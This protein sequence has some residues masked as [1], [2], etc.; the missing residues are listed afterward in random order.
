MSNSL[1]QKIGSFDGISHHITA[2]A[3]IT[4]P[5]HGLFNFIRLLK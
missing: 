1:R 3:T 5:K 4:M 2:H